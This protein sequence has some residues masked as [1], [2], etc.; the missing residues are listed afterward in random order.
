VEYIRVATKA[1]EETLPVQGVLV[2]I[3]YT[4]NAKF[5][6]A[7]AK[8]DCGEIKVNNKNETTVP[9]I[10]AAGDVTDVPTKQIIVAAGE[11]AKASIWAADYVMRWA[12]MTENPV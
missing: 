9:G 3:G 2:E 5:V 1:G 11:G 8:N 4:P 12:S 10:F 7:V 6:G